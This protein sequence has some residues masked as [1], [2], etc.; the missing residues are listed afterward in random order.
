M[1]DYQQNSEIL[2][3][4][5]KSC[6]A[7]SS[8]GYHNCKVYKIMQGLCIEAGDTSKNDGS[9]SQLENSCKTYPKQFMGKHVYAG[10]L[11]SMLEVDGSVGT[12][13]SITLKKTPIFDGGRF[14]I[15]RIV[16]GLDVLA[17]LEQFGT[18]FGCPKKEVFIENCG[19][20]K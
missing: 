1:L 13:F 4:F 5:I 2:K 6:L 20:L 11:S 10:T 17:A 12:K 19:L 18:R 15:G 9:G 8:S 16:K 7:T 3:N 14:V